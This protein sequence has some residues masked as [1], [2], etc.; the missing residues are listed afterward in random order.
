MKYT[1]IILLLFLLP[2]LT[3]GQLKDTTYLKKITE[4]LTNKEANGRQTGGSGEFF[5]ASLIQKE[6]EKIGIDAYS[7]SYFHSFSFDFVKKDS[8]TTQ[9]NGNNVIGFIDNFKSKTIV[10]GAH[11][12]HLGENEFGQGRTINHNSHFYPGA[13]DNAS[14]V[15]LLLNLAKDLYAKR[16][17]LN[18]NYIIAFFSAEELGLHG[19]KNFV[20]DLS[21]NQIA[22]HAMLNFDM[23]GRLIPEKKLVVDGV[24][25]AKVFDSLLNIAQQSS[26]LVLDKNDSGVGGSDYT[27]FYLNDIPSVSFTTGV[28]NDYHTVKDTE[29]KL[30]Y[31]GM[32]EIKGFI[33]DFLQHLEQ[34]EITFQ[35]TKV[36]ETKKRSKLKV[37]LGIMPSY[38]SDSGLVI[39][40]VIKGKTA[41]FYGFIEKDVIIGI[42]NCDVTSIYDYMDC[43]STFDE[44]DEAI[45]RILRSNKKKKIKVVF[46]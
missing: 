37:S 24:A 6:L 28:H 14:G 29:N 12:D 22:I 44:G 41:D 11:Y 1:T 43:L 23:V 33:A 32:I 39:D 21:E 9:L 15:A 25:S 35:E 17:L 7:K 27:S 3:W 10:L 42:N 31:T 36:N 40:A 5:S 38:S 34:S 8:N 2:S 46:K 26:S 19:S 20:K 4:Q 30:N 18:A 45:I 16:E 13:D